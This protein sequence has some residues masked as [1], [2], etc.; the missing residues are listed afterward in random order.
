MPRYRYTSPWPAV[1]SD[2][3]IGRTTRVIPSDGRPA[4]VPGSTVILLPGDE[5]E[6][7]DPCAHAWLAEV[8]RSLAPGESL[9][10]PTDAASP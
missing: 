1:F 7:A 2:L 8:E 6:T 5:I 3:E 10:P 4:P 9:D